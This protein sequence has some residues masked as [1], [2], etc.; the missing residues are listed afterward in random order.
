M[1]GSSATVVR[2]EH[3]RAFDRDA[4]ARVIEQAAR[5]A[6]D[7]ERLSTSLRAIIELLQEADQLAADAG[8]E[9]VGAAEVQAAIDAQIRRGDRIYRRMQE[10][11]GRRTIRI[12]TDGEVVGQINGLSVI[13]L[14][15]LAFG[16][17]T[18]ITA[19]VR[20]GRGE[21]V[22]IERE[23]QL[24]GPLHSKGVLILTG[25]LGGRFGGE[26]PLSLHASLV[27]EQSYGGVDGDSAS[28]AE[29]FALLRRWPRCRSGN[30]SRSPARSISMAI[31]QA[32]GGVNEKIEG[33][34]DICKAAGLTGR[35]G[36]IIPAS[37]VK[38]LMLRA[39]V[40]AAAAAGQF[41]SHPDGDD[42]PGLRTVDRRA[43]RDDQSKRSPRGSTSSPPRRPR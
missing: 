14:G 29:L 3:L 16:N 27:F 6:G 18:R 28:A 22:D 1:R 13:S 31:I 38:H 40:V 35:Q 10:E 15:A 43:D 33:F 8:K 20:M 23:V 12:E 4:V 25:F 42:R 36:V 7:A 24:G 37:N 26:R 17:P 5:L 34:F 11:I 21:I 39:E 2:R 19:Q 41:R 32:I 9:V 30:A